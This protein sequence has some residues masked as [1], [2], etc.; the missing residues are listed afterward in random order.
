M[1]P[2]RV[3]AGGTR[4]GENR[5]ECERTESG[6]D[7]GASENGQLAAAGS[8]RAV[9]AELSADEAGVDA[10]SRRRGEG[11]AAIEQRF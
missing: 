4:I 3:P 1:T 2:F 11:V 8:G 10:V 7:D 5:V 6:R 9:G